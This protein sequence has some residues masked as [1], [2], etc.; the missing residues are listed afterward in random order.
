MSD[1]LT[2]DERHQLNRWWRQY[3]A[4]RTTPDRDA[5]RR[6]IELYLE[7]RTVRRVTLDLQSF[8]DERNK[9]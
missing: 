8:H 3:D 7:G 1:F 4:A 6:I 9:S 2:P 5:V